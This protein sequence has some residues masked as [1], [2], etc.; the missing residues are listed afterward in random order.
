MGILDRMRHKKSVPAPSATEEKP[1]RTLAEDIPVAADWVA[2]A[3]NSSG[4]RADYTLES[5]KELDRFFDQQS[6]PGGI[7]SRNRGQI[8]FGLGAYVGQTAIRLYGGS[9]QTDDNDPEG[10]VIIAVEL[11]NGTRIWPVVR[12]MKRCKLVA[13]ESLFAYLMVLGEKR[14]GDSE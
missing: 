14:Q 9:W 3:L 4:Y 8:L 6:G 12:C 5:M 1:G 13:E 2:N 11:E 7:L 10:E